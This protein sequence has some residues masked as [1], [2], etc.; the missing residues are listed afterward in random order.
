MVM[1]FQIWG[2]GFRQGVGLLTWGWDSRHGNGVPD[3]V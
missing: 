3:K 2:W 1:G